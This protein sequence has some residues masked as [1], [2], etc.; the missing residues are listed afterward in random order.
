MRRK[1]FLVQEEF[2]PYQLRFI[3][4]W[5]EKKKY[6]TREYLSV[7][8]ILELL[9]A[10]THTLEKDGSDG[11]FFNNLLHNEES[12]IG[13]DGEDLTDILLY[14]LKKNINMTLSGGRTFNDVI[15]NPLEIIDNKD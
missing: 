4:L 3:E 8:D 12:I 6:S 9:I 14:Q 11:R 5:R 15:D 1:V 10:T 7:G 2:S 13:W